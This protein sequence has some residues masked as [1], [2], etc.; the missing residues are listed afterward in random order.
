MNI[1]E[2]LSEED[3]RELLFDL[4]NAYKGFYTMLE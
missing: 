3:T 1:N 2:E 4:D